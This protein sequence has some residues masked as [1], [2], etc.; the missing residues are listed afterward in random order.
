VPEK[1]EKELSDIAMVS[2]LACQEHK[3]L[4]IRKQGDKSWF[5]FENTEAL[6]TDMMKFLNRE[7]TVDPL[8][9]NETLRNLK[10]LAKQG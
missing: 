10:S 1:N 8:K 2:Y 5:I 4:R 7:A 9:F 3:I 6:E